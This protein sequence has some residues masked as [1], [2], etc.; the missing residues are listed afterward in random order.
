LALALWLAVTQVRVPLP[1][2]RGTAR[3]G[4]QFDCQV[5]DGHAP[6]ETRRIA[7][8]L[9]KY[10]TKG[11]DDAGALDR[12]VVGMGDLRL[13]TLPPQLRRM[14]ETAWQL[15]GDE[16]LALLRLRAWTHTLGVRTHF[17]TKSRHF[18]ATFRLLRDKR[19]T[20]RRAE[21]GA[22]GASVHAT[23]IVVADWKFVGRG[24]SAGEAYLATSEARH[25]AESRRLAYEDRV[26]QCGAGV[27]RGDD[28]QGHRA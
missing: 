22:V 10:A 1:D 19:Q 12:R 14:A 8:Y 15:G 18:S 9:A 17:L 4:D 11:S 7:A 3:W 24:W 25:R 28:G 21:H 16:A 6:E 27:H 13:R 26:L 5:L 20:W 2:N 23:L